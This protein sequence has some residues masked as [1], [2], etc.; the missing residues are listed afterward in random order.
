MTTGCGASWCL[1]VDTSG[2]RKG[3]IDA[4]FSLDM[5]RVVCLIANK[6]VTAV[7]AVKPHPTCLD[8]CPTVS[9]WSL[10]ALRLWLLGW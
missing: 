7:M 1:R 5:I 8:G 9:E 3:L 6:A 10:A 2:E 4:C